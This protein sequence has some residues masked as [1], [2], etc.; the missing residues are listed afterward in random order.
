MRVRP[1]GSTAQTD[2]GGLPT[3][4][5]NSALAVT[6]LTSVL[7]VSRLRWSSLVETPNKIGGI[8]YWP[9][10]TKDAFVF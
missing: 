8:G 2:A 9:F 1:A 6:R 3:E 7:E 4:D 5:S 10:H